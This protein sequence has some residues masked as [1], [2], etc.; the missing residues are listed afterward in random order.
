MFYEP[1]KGHG[2]P[3]GCLC[4]GAIAQSLLNL[5]DAPVIL[6]FFA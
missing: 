1:E 3:H 6:V 5:A 2:L 4:L